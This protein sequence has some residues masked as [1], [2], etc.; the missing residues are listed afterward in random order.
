MTGPPQR[1]ARAGSAPT[2][3]LK[4]RVNALRWEPGSERHHL[5]IGRRCADR[6]D[7]FGSP[8]DAVP[9]V[10]FI[11]VGLG[12]VLSKV[13]GLA[14]MSFFGRMPS[15]DDDRI[16]LV[17]IL[18]LTWL[19]LLVGGL[20]PGFAELFIPFVEDATAAQVASAALAAVL[21]LAIGGIT[22]TMHNNRGAG[23][24][25]GYIFSG[26]VYAAVIGLTVTGIVVTVPVLKASY[27][28]RRFAVARVMI[29][30]P[31]GRY[32]EAFERVHSILEDV[33]IHARAEE[34]NP[35]IRGHFRALGWILGRVFRRDI[36]D[37]MRVL[38]GRQDGDW[39]EVTVHAADISIIGTRRVVHRVRATLVEHLGDE[40][41]YLTWDDTS[42]Q[43]EDDA[44]SYRARIRDGEP[45]ARAD[46]ATLVDRLAGVQL[47]QEPWDA[48]RRM[49]YRLECDNERLRADLGD[50]ADATRLASSP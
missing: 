42:Q 24:V 2:S 18:S 36:A 48:L 17:G 49:L 4:H 20:W 8:E 39:F 34:I 22:A 43:L 38:R 40:V 7:P 28:V 15:R 21:P 3:H 44:A 27:L 5:V 19:T 47:D 29:M 41:I 37:D 32:D 10:R 12:K 14:T 16:A 50:E 26:Y 11:I 31:A 30:I 13:F 23:P 45:V 46:I 1:E 25:L 35:V 33:G 6:T 9:I